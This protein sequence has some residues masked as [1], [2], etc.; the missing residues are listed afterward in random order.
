M[1]ELSKHLG[2]VGE[3][4]VLLAGLFLLLSM[5]QPLRQWAQ[6]QFSCGTKLIVGL[7]GAADARSH[8]LHRWTVA[9]RMVF[10]ERRGL[11]IIVGA[12]IVFDLTLSGYKLLIHFLVAVELRCFPPPGGTR[13]AGR[14]CPMMSICHIE[15]RDLAKCLFQAGEIR[16]SPDG[17][18]HSIRGHEVIQRLLGRTHGFDCGVDA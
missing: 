11:L 7:Y 10:R 2:P 1:A 12:L 8:G 14:R 4:F 18:N 16:N 9:F 13:A 15:R 6:G 5:H 3:F 17:M